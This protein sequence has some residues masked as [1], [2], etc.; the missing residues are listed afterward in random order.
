MQENIGRLSLRTTNF[1][2]YR[3]VTAW[4]INCLTK[5][6]HVYTGHILKYCW[7]GTFVVATNFDLSLPE[8][9][10]EKGLSTFRRHKGCK[11]N[12]TEDDEGDVMTAADQVHTTPLPVRRMRNNVRKRGGRFWATRTL[13]LN[14]VWRPCQQ[15]HTFTSSCTVQCTAIIMYK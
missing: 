11:R 13:T 14:V 1:H 6:W 12:C 10:L 7:Q 4:A 3:F 8:E 2:K 9:L 5:W 15:S